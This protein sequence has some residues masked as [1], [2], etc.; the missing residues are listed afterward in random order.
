MTPCLDTNFPPN[1]IAYLDRQRQ[2]YAE[3]PNP[4]P[5][6]DRQRQAYAERP[7]PNPNLD[8]QRQA[9]AERPNPNPNPN[10][11]RQGQAYAERPDPNPN[12]DRQRQAY[13]ETSLC[14]ENSWPQEVMV[15]PCESLPPAT[16]VSPASLQLS[17][18]PSPPATT[19]ILQW[20]L[21]PPTDL[22]GTLN[23]PS[24]DLR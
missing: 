12:L 19:H 7:K 4:N 23:R 5:N 14:T 8:R 18:Q 22:P 13:A 9:Y 10:L 24:M 1:T 16:A 3:R 6:L 21:S 2:A 15:I 11:D 20:I 17:L